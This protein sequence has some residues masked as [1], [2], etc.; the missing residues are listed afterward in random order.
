MNIDIETLR[1]QLAVRMTALK[2]EMASAQHWAALTP[3]QRR[4]NAMK[5]YA[6]GWHA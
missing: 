4:A 3:A 2:A 1:R 5:R 6:F